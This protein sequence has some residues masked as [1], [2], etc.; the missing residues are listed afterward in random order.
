[1][2]D[3]RRKIITMAPKVQGPPDQAL[4]AIP[5]AMSDAVVKQAADTTAVLQQTLQDVFHG[6]PS[7]R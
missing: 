6:L 3:H 4:P 1:M 7:V 2:G 5:A